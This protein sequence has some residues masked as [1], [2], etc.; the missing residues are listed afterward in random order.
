MGDGLSLRRF[1]NPCPVQE[2]E[3]VMTEFEEGLK[4]GR[5]KLIEFSQKD[6]E[7][8]NNFVCRSELFAILEAMLPVGICKHGFPYEKCTMGGCVKPE[9]KEQE[10]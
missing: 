3:G 5:G 6:K 1:F 4:R 9:F 7:N 10:K 2:G 8:C